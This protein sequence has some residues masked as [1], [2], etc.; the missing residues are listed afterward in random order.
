MSINILILEPDKKTAIQIQTIAKSLNCYIVGMASDSKTACRIAKK[1]PIDLFIGDIL[2]G[3]TQEAIEGCRI[4]QQQ[5]G[6]SIILVA[7]GA[8]TQ[9]IK[10]LSPLKINGYLIKPIHLENLKA[11]IRI[12]IFRKTVAEDE[13]YFFDDVY[14]YCLKC[15]NL[16]QD[17]DTVVLNKKEHR[18][19]LAL[20]ECSGALLS[21]EVMKQRV[22]GEE[23]VSP[24]ARRQ[25]IHRF[26]S[27]APYFPLKL[28]KGLGVLYRES[29]GRVKQ[30]H[31]MHIKR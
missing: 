6:F 16:F 17:R 14:C 5:Q 21:H 23:T 18:L 26:R 24:S 25:F 3:D 1:S 22:W 7:D 27:K 13:C 20:V 2:S 11:L 19:M 9:A 30:K 29:G 12:A 28:V 10:Q 15:A 8:D 31:L 4:L